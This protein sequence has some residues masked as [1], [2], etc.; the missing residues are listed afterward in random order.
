VRRTH[1][2]ST[3]LYRKKLPTTRATP[4]GDPHTPDSQASDNGLPTTAGGRTGTDIGLRTTA[5]EPSLE[6]KATKLKEP[7]PSGRGGAVQWR[8]QAQEGAA[9][10]RAG[11]QALLTERSTRRLSSKQAGSQEA[12]CE[13][14]GRAGGTTVTVV[15]Q[16]LNLCACPGLPV[17][18]TMPKISTLKA[19]NYGPD[20]TTM[21]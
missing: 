8:L 15:E 20:P 11:S 18:E 1:D 17:N 14:P 12:S 4:T 3:L 9:R 13:G 2:Y 16:P 21:D 5:P 10:G 6:T 7:E 19:K